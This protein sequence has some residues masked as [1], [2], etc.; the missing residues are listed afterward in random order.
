MFVPSPPS[1]RASSLS[2]PSRLKVGLGVL[3]ELAGVGAQ[4]PASQG[5]SAGLRLSPGTSCPFWA[6]PV[7]QTPKCRC[8]RGKSLERKGGR[9]EHT[10]CLILRPQGEQRCRM[11]AVGAPAQVTCPREAGVCSQRAFAA[12]LCRACH[13]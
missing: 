1:L 6:R 3:W 2:C 10:V 8:H 13:I 11:E 9:G 4:D 5:P 12:P 7:V